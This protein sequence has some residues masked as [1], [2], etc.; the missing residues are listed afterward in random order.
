MLDCIL[1]EVAGFT[2]IAA[3]AFVNR[4]AWHTTEIT[5][6]GAF[7]MEWHVLVLVHNIIFGGGRRVKNKI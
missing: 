5:A 6:I 2:R 3:R 7:D 1:D 4:L